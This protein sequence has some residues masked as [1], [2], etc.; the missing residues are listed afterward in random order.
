M[1]KT[2]VII[3]IVF[4]A[5]L[6]LAGCVQKIA[7]K[8]EMAKQPEVKTTPQQSA[9]ETIAGSQGELPAGV[10]AAKVPEFE[11]VDTDLGDIV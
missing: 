10:D 3:S 11:E 9:P 5:L 7:K 2:L 6:L 8:Q 1:K 4:M